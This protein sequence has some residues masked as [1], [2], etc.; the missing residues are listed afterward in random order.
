MREAA[1]YTWFMVDRYLT[2]K[3]NVRLTRTRG[4]PSIRCHIGVLARQF[5]V[6]S[7]AML[8]AGQ[9]K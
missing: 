2:E 9:Q 5:G 1:I 7:E 4:L 3:E 6:R 8:G